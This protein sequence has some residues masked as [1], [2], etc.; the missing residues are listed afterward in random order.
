MA[1]TFHF[2]RSSFNYAALHGV[3]APQIL[4][5][6]SGVL[7]I[8]GGLSVALGYKTKYGAW[9]LVAFLVPVTFTMHAFWKETNVMMMT[10]QTTNFMKNLALIGG[11]LILAY[12][13]AGPLSLDNY[14]EDHLERKRI[15]N[16][17]ITKVLKG[18]I[19]ED[20]KD[21]IKVNAFSESLE[22]IELQHFWQNPD[23][24]NEVILLFR[25]NNMTDAKD[26]IK[27]NYNSGKAGQ[28]IPLLQQGLV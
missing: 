19:P 11:S 2:S 9:L 8:L 10:M 3:P 4:V 23:D 6:F 26:L 12:Y 22:D 21:K 16:Y 15:R 18:K 20:T 25:T 24:P 7:A 17:E 14:I 27:K 28:V 1:V 13:G 5:P